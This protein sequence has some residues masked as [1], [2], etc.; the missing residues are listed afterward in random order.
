[1]CPLVYFKQRWVPQP[2]FWNRYRASAPWPTENA[3]AT[4]AT[5]LTRAL[6]GGGGVWT[7]AQ[8]FE[9]SENMAGSTHLMPHVFRSFGE[10]FDSRSC[11][12][13]S[14]GQVKWPN[15]KITFQSRH[16]YNVLGKVMKPSESDKVISAY[17]TYISVFYIGDLSQVIFAT[18]PM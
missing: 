14:P 11:K 10:N 12:V 3:T 4:S 8:V 17:K 9:D 15:Y 18:S 16:G 7:P 6:L 13:R 1:M 5:F 2:M